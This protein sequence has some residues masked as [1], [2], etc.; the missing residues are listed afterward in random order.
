MK[1]TK[2]TTR[3]LAPAALF[4][5]AMAGAS[6]AMAQIMAEARAAYQRGDYAAALRGLR[7]HAE[8]GDAVAQSMVGTMYARGQGVD[9]DA[10]EALKWL[11][12]AVEGGE[13]HAQ[14]NL[15]T[16]LMGGADADYAQAYKWLG[17]AAVRLPESKRAMSG[18]AARFRDLAAMFLTP[19]ELA[20][21]RRLTR[22]WRP[23]KE[24]PPAK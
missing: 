3:L 11:R 9:E 14:Y 12:L 17:L 5:L 20:R 21:A 7:L 1:M 23:R 22:E 16:M 2:R 24:T 10:A 15:G 18:K 13:A 6:P 8:R 19:Q 4:L